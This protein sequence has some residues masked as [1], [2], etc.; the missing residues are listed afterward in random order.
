MNESALKSKKFAQLFLK[1]N[2]EVWLAAS[3]LVSNAPFSHRMLVFSHHTTN[4]P[5]PTTN[6][7]FPFFSFLSLSH[8]QVDELGDVSTLAD[9]S[10]VQ[11]II[12]KNNILRG[13]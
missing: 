1:H 11:E 5:H 12:K 3:V 13:K 2:A 7:P 8:T 4:T 10:V 9:P 6:L